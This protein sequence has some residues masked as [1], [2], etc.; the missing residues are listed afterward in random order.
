MRLGCQAA[1]ILVVADVVR[2]SGEIST[3]T[4]S[5]ALVV[6]LLTFE[7]DVKRALG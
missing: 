1:L 6:H 2:R 7:C 4:L 3:E 5:K